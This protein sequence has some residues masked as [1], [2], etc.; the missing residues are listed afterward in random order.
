MGMLFPGLILAGL[1]I[2]Y[3]LGRCMI[4]P[5]DGQRLPPDENDPAFMQKIWITAIALVPPLIL[6]F[7]VLGTIM[8]GW[9]TPTEA[10]AMGAAGSVIMTLAYG[11]FTLK[12]LKEAL[13]K[14]TLVTAMIL[15]I[16]LAGK[17]FATVFT[18]SGGLVGTQQ[19][20]SAANLSG[21]ET[22]GILL[23]L[24]FIAGFVLD[25]IS[26]ILIIIPIA[27]PLIE[28]F[29]FY[30][31][32]ANQVKTWFCILFLI[33]IQTSYLTPPMAPAIFYLRGISPPEIRLVH[34]YKGVLP[35]IVLEVIALALVI[36]VPA[37]ALW[38]PE[39]MLNMRFK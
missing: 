24:A 2:I 29:D 37:L 36:L 4:W 30:G 6:I 20:V 19:L 33:V 17:I 35:F 32:D 12:A 22:L 27:M 1:Y 13:V 18:I 25:L 8:L 11:N 15:M 26:I 9:A 39:Q 14:T 21:W 3:I 34:M 10:A 31:M 23:L 16:L 5:E 38:L 7:S 28:Q